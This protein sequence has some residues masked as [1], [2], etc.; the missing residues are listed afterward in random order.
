LDCR[1][2][3]RW[4][5]WTCADDDKADEDD[6]NRD[7]EQDKE[8]DDKYDR[9]NEEE[10]EDLTKDQQ[11]QTNSNQHHKDEGQGDHEAEEEEEQSDDDANAV[12]LE[13]ETNSQ[14]SELRS[15]ARESQPVLRLK[16]KMSRKLYVQNNKKT[17][18]KVVFA[19]DKLKQLE[20]CHNLVV[21]Q[22]KPTEEQTIEYGSNQ[23]M[24]I[25]RFI[26]DI[27]RNVNEHGASFAQQYILQKGRRQKE[28]GTNGADVSHRQE[29]QER[30]R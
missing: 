9:I 16:P 21:S 22:V 30:E 28:E 10:L 27:T 24:L 23:A 7:Q 11:E 13:Q 5:H 12:I 18:K 4:K 25:V 29:R 2:G 6:E 19:E 3:L 17:I 8:K 14:G 1:S 20:Y 15:S 26:Q